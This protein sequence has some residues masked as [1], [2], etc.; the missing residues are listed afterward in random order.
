[1]VD[2]RKQPAKL[3]TTTAKAAADY[4]EKAIDEIFCCVIIVMFVHWTKSSN[5]QRI[6]NGGG[7]VPAY[8]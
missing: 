7:L 8:V 2:P 3:Q 4:F 6:S 1:M 5:K